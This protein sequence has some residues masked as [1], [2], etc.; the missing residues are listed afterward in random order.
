MSQLFPRI[1]C[2]ITGHR[3]NVEFG[4][5]FFASVP[6][7][8][9]AHFHVDDVVKS[10][11]DKAQCLLSLVSVP[12]G[13]SPFYPKSRFPKRGLKGRFDFFFRGFH[14]WSIRFYSALTSNNRRYLLIATNIT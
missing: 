2:E 3:R 8:I 14:F 1:L 10:G 9:E 13:M 5:D 7:L 4:K 11:A 6:F 12:E